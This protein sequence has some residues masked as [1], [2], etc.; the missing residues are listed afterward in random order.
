MSNKFTDLFGG[1]ENERLQETFVDCEIKNVKI[2]MEKKSIVIDAFFPRLVT[3][4]YIAKPEEI[5][6]EKLLVN[7]VKIESQMPSEC[8]SEGYYG[9]L[10]K[11]LNLTLAASTGFFEGSKCTFDGRVLSCE[12]MHGGKDVLDSIRAAD[13]MSAI[14]KKR[15]SRSVDV[16]FTGKTEISL[17]DEQVTQMIKTSEENNLRAKGID[18]ETIAQPKTQSHKIIE[19]IPLIWKLPNRSTAIKLLKI[20]CL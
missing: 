13:Y 8:F 12:L 2:A 5:L 11:E 16:V 6:K 14:I 7:A 1:F 3:F 10:I 17:E 4:N 19:G 18:P 20:L 9:S 15:F